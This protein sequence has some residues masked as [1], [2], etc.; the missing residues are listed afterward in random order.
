MSSK[1]LL[2]SLLSL[3]VPGLGQMVAG[4]GQRGGAILLM[5]IVV[6]NLNAIWLSLF[7]LTSHPSGNSAFWVY[8]L[9]LLLHRLFAAHGVIFWIWQTVDAYVQVK[10]GTQIVQPQ[11]RFS[12]T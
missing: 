11:L 2:V 6:G 1:A 12:E 7:S 9:P 5:V 10:R 8:T 4:K 3:L